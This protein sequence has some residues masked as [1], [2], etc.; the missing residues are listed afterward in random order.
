MTVKSFYRNPVTALMQ[1]AIRGTSTRRELIKRG[2][3]LGLSGAVMG[4]ILRAESVGAQAA[5][6]ASPEA[7]QPVGWSLA[8]PEWLRTDLSGMTVSAVLGADGPGAPFDQAC[9]DFFAEHTGATVNYIKGAESAT[10]RLTFLSQTFAAG[11]ADVDVAQIDVIWPGTLAIHSVDLSQQLQEIQDT[12]VTFFDRIVQNNTVN[13]ALVGIPWF[14][15]AGLLYYRTDLLEKY[16]YSKAPE[17]WQELEDMAT[18]IMEGEVGAN[19]AFTGFT[20]QASAYE[21]LTCN[22]LEWKFSNGG[23]TIVDENAEI[24]INN[25]Q[26]RAALERAKG[27]VGTIAPDAVTGYKEEDSRGVWQGG[28]AAFHRNWPYVYSISAADDSDLQGKFDIAQLPRGD[29]DGA[30]HAATLGGWQQF[31]SR[32]SENQDAAKEFAK[33]MSSPE[34]QK[35]RALERSQLP[36]IGELYQDED[37]LAANPF[38]G[39]LFDT[40]SSG[41]VARPSTSTADLYPQVSV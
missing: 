28:N 16:G 41:S 19:S 32:Y 1:D 11:S 12:G 5:T 4:A 27:W 24:T 23:G 36:T 26:A 30:S 29:G 14:T 38:F 15:D 35:A 2:S 13:D 3:A 25:D 7:A 34:V 22:G 8:A 18:T 31:V 40:F 21:G 20:F 9:C 17:T 6:D 37:V 33:F 39:Q 10:D